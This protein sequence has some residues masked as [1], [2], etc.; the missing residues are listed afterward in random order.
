MI[1][2]IIPT[3]GVRRGLTCKGSRCTLMFME[4]IADYLEHRR[5]LLADLV[6][7]D[8][9]RLKPG[10]R[11]WKLYC[12][13]PKEGRAAALEHRIYTKR[14]LDGRLALVTFARHAPEPG[15]VVRSGI[16]RVADLSAD[17]LD[18]IIEAIRKETHLGQDE[19]E[20]VD[21]SM[22]ASLDDQIARL[23]DLGGV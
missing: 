14:K 6:E 5:G 13:R 9:L 3:I 19:Q 11:L 4:K 16:A 22:L 21:L 18:R 20:E 2:I 23:R 15:R 1:S 10:E 7:E 12:F 17:I 8:M